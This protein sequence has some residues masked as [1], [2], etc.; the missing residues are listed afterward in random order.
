MTSLDLLDFFQ[1]LSLSR[2]SRGLEWKALRRADR[3][4]TICESLRDD[5]QARGVPATKLFQAPN[6]VD[7]QVFTPREPRLTLASDGN[8]RRRLLVGSKGIEIKPVV[9]ILL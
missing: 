6:G 2:L 8:P 7:T 4:V 9:P 1:S 3:V 5:L